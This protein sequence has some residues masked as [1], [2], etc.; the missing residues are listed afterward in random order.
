MVDS[1]PSPPPPA[2]AAAA[3][4]AAAPAATSL[5]LVLIERGKT[6]ADRAFELEVTADADAAV[7][8]PPRGASRDGGGGG[9]GGGGRGLVPS[10]S[11]EPRQ[12]SRET[13]RAAL[14]AVPLAV[15]CCIAGVFSLPSTAVRRCGCGSG[16]GGDRR[17]LSRGR[18]CIP[19]GC[20]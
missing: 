8:A 7:A 15:V 14:E 19:S 20:P 5:A 10:A 12:S 4:A 17:H 9:G 2:A 3:A 13:A 18:R 1:P 6:F 16:N 11:T